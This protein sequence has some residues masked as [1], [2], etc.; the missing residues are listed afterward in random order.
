MCG[1]G[2]RDYI[3]WRGFTINEANALS[4]SDTGPV[5]FVNTVGS[6]LEGS[7]ITGVGNNGRQDN[8]TGV[9]ID[10]G[11]GVIV[12]NN[13]IAN[14]LGYG[15]NSAGIMTYYSGQLLI[16]NN[17]ITNTGSGIYLKANFN[18]TDWV[19]IRYNHIHGIQTGGIDVHRQPSTA[20]APVKIY[21]NVIR[22]S[23]AGIKLHGFDGE[24][25]DARN[26]KIV[27]NTLVNNTQ[28][29]HIL[30]AMVDN[31]GHMFWNNLVYGGNN[32]VYMEGPAGNVTPARIDFE[33]NLYFGSGSVAEV[34]TVGYSL[35]SWKNSL[36][37]DS[38][39][40]AAISQN[41]NFVNLSGFDFRL[42]ASSPARNLGVDALDLDNDGNTT[43]LIA[44]GAYITG[45]ETIGRTSSAS[46]SSL[47]STPTGLRIVVPGQ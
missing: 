26:V 1:G 35:A 11:R 9:R 29:M 23:S 37:Q 32:G 17:E 12:R 46:G 38:A 18:N 10:T 41:P 39:A 15:R 42:Q 31:A 13:R 25:T 4:V 5:V 2:N 8:Y 21:Q 3:A 14:F 16:E 40:P 33:H 34:A 24:A 7:E 30:Y 27:N 47:P 36:S 43:E 44:A 28:N 6:M 20:S 19:T 45:N 22:N